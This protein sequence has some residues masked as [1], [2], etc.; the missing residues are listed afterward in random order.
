MPRQSVTDV[1]LKLGL[2]QSAAGRAVQRGQG[3]A[4]ASGLNL[5]YSQKRI[6]A[7]ASPLTLT[8]AVRRDFDLI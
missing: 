3:I 6:N 7:W 4:E 5:E 1:G 2:S 8:L